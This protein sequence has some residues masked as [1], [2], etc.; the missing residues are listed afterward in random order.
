ENKTFEVQ[1]IITHKKVLDKYE[2]LVKWKNYKK[3][4]NSWVK[5]HD[6]INKDIIKDYWN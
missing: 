2:F 6:F 5:E 3:D 4:Y 1:Y